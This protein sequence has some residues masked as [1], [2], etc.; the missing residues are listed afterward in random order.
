MDHHFDRIDRKES[1]YFWYVFG[2]FHEV[3]V[4][5]QEESGTY[6]DPAIGSDAAIIGGGCAVRF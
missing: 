5:R 3:N 6:D 1:V 2:K 4:T